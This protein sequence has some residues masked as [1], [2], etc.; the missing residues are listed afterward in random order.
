M[1]TGNIDQQ[2]DP[3]L[4]F[5]GFSTDDENDPDAMSLVEHLEELRWRILKC[6]IA[7]LVFSVVAFIFR[8]YILHF[9]EAPLPAT[10]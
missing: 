4:T 8:E 1:A 10:H 2:Q 7:V 5:D 9:L 6:L 3:L